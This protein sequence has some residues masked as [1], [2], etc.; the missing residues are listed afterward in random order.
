MTAKPW[1]LLGRPYLD[2]SPFLDAAKVAALDREIL[3]GLAE[4]ETGA[5]GATLKWMG[6]VAPW[7]RHDGH[8]DAMEAIRA[9]DADDFEQFVALG[10]ADVDLGQQATLEFGDETDQPF[11]AAQ[12]RL[13]LFRHGVYFPWKVCH[14]LLENDRWED[15]HSGAGK[16]F[17]DE[18]REHFPQ[19]VA[20]VESLPF[21]E[22]GRCVIFGLMPGDHAPLHRDTEPG[23][24]QVA[25]SITFAPRPGKRL[26]LQNAPDAE[27]V[28]VQ[29][30][31]Y[32][33][34]DMDYHGVL[35]DPTFRYSVRVDGVFEPDFVRLL[36][37]AARR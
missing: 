15:K 37:R 31:L 27:P 5:T 22:M 23:A 13:L 21:V 6:V 4:V 2:L 33:F 11:T 25:Q 32:W 29:A 7:M 20:F 35:A 9:M 12:V 28:I 30:P 26:Y 10:D 18:A 36:E 3:G 34:N 19:T 24:L 8:R 17:S 14:H 16:D 1:G